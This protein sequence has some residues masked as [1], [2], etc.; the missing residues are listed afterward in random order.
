MEGD[1]LKDD[2]I[3]QFMAFLKR[4]GFYTEYVYN[5]VRNKETRYEDIKE[6]GFANFKDL[7]TKR[8]E[9]GYP[10]S[11]EDYGALLFTF[12]AFN[13]S[14]AN[15]GLKLGHGFQKKWASVVIKWALYCRKHEISVCD[16]YA[17]THL[18]RYYRD[19]DWLQWDMFT[20]EEQKMI[21]DYI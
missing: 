14:S 7:I 3:R 16:N 17:L 13:W 10:S 6:N 4:N 20:E 8:K 12:S 18:L 19:K 21:N 9:R 15:V 5:L 1:F 2:V 11:Y